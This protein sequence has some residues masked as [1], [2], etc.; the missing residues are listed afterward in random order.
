MVE[1]IWA[2]RK[3]SVLSLS[4]LACLAQLPAINL[5][6]GCAHDCIYCY[7]RGY[8]GFPGENKVVIYKD[9]LDKLKAELLHRRSKPQGVY[10]SPSSDIFQPI[11]QVLEISHSILD[12]LL[13]KGMGV[14]FLT[15]GRIPEKTLGL[16]LDH[17]DKV[18]AQVGIITHDDSIRSTFE[19]NAATVNMRLAQMAK[20]VAG[21]V[22][23][24]A[25]IVPILPGITDTFNAIEHLCDAISRTGV[26]KAA[27]STLFLR[28]AIAASLGR[29]ISDKDILNSLL[30]FYRDRTRVAIHA[31]HSSVIPL[32][33]LKRKE[34]YSSFLEAARKYAI[35]LSICGCMNPD[36]G[37][38][39]NITG[40]W[41]KSAVQMTNR[42]NKLF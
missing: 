40:S 34:I 16:L 36:I 26:R 42:I 17:A 12:F 2:E 39:C 22:D 7:G 14:A 25:R 23:I 18:R 35:A 30:S 11:P 9:I 41:A 33:R 8:S 3:S 20:L 31:D 15:K 6:M 5:T 32:S 21:G 37:G 28:P 10:F 29:R 13:S 4:S 24:E 1:V 27:M 38:T 19:P